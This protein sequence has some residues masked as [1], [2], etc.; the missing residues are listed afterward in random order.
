MIILLKVIR[1][2][3]N[4][5]SDN[6]PEIYIMSVIWLCLFIVTFSF[7]I[8]SQFYTNSAN[9]ENVLVELHG[10]LIELAIV[11]IIVTWILSKK[12][13]KDYQGIKCLQYTRLLRC[14]SDIIETFPISSLKESIFYCFGSNRVIAS[15]GLKNIDS[16]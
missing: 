10:T 6:Q 12:T 7:G 9:F 15:V 2:K 11:G 4:Q 8:Y 1:N 5:L 14:S 13:Q 3:I 16:D